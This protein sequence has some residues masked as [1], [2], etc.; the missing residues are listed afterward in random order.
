[1]S[2]E[3]KGELLLSVYEELRNGRHLNRTE[4]CQEHNISQPTFY[5]Y[6]SEI[7][8]FLAENHPSYILTTDGENCF[9][10]TRRR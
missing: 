2:S 1:M 6:M 7:R 5:R 3:K 8:A 10:L 4:F 9:F